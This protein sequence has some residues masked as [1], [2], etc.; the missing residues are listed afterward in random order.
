MCFRKSSA[1][2]TLL[3]QSLLLHPALGLLKWCCAG[4]LM[5]WWHLTGFAFLFCGFQYF[6]TLHISNWSLREKCSHTFLA[7]SQF[8]LLPPGYL[9]LHISWYRLLFFFRPCFFHAL[10]P[11]ILLA[12]NFLLIKQ[13]TS[14]EGPL[15][16]VPNRERKNR[17]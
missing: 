6:S 4:S 12:L 5:T 13:M 7:S 3:S 10:P 1:F 2:T 8:S 15:F 14:G 16:C 17:D 11:F 9:F